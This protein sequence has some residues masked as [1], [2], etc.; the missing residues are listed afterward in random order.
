MWDVDVHSFSKGYI[1]ALV[2][3]PDNTK[4][5]TCFYGNPSAMNQK[6]SWQ[7]LRRLSCMFDLPWICG[8]DFNK[9]TSVNEK[10]GG[11][12]RHSSAILDFQLALSD[13]ELLDLGFSGLLLT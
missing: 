13:C 12:D 5:F 8:G 2:Q 11:Q 9:I 10:L 3:G 4:R 1:D 6:F 7:L